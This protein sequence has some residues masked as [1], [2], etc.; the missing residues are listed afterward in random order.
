MYMD[1]MQ[2]EQFRD[3]VYDLLQRLTARAG[4]PPKP[5]YILAPEPMTTFYANIDN[6]LREGMRHIGYALSDIPTGAYV[7]A[8]DARL[9]ERPRGVISTG[10][11][12]VEIVLKIFDSVSE[13]ARMLSDEVGRYYIQGAE[14]LNIKPAMYKM[15]PSRE[16]IIRQ[17][18]GF[19]P[20]EP[21]RTATQYSRTPAETMPPRPETVVTRPRVMQEPSNINTSPQPMVQPMSQPVP[22]AP[23]N[24]NYDGPSQAVMIDSNGVSYDNDAAVPQVNSEPLSPRDSVSHYVEY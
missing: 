13:D 1:A 14:T 6:D 20:A 8:Y 19:S 11:P 24:N 2:A 15:L 10:E 18:E 9:L 22:R 3:A 16:K 17:S 23:I 5:I 21:P 4:M 7:F 12:N